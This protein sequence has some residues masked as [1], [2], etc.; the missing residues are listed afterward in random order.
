MSL[1]MVLFT[2][3]SC[4]VDIQ[5]MDYTTKQNQTQMQNTNINKENAI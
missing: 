4:T 3:S 1:D 2:S 5:G